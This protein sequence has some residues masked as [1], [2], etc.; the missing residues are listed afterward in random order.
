MAFCKYCGTQLQDGELCNCE[1]AVAS[2]TAAENPAPA[3]T[4]QVNIPVVGNIDYNEVIN[5][6]KNIAGG[7]LGNFLAI[8]TK[9][10]DG[11]ASFVKN[12]KISES[13][14][15][16]VIQAV[17]SGIL[18]CSVMVPII[19]SLSGGM[20]SQ[21]DSIGAG[22]FVLVTLISLVVSLIYTLVI[23]AVLRIARAT[24]GFK[25]AVCLSSLRSAAAIPFTIMGLIVCLINTGVGLAINAIPLFLSLFFLVYGMEG[26]E[27]VEKNKKAHLVSVMV[28][29]SICIIYFISSSLLEKLLTAML[30]DMA[31]SLGSILSIFQNMY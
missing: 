11:S 29:I 21:D 28:L 16:M 20:A 22:C 4:T 8:W 6:G 25:N 10:I 31:S 24:E 12:G 30:G 18:G 3:P 1:K 7:L 17:F 27:S 2:R 14:L 26:I 19:D 5:K 15:F 23:F 13:L 9:P